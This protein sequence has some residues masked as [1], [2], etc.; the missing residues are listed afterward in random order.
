MWVY[1]ADGRR[2]PGP[3]RAQVWAVEVL[4][5][6]PQA[7]LIYELETLHLMMRRT[8]GRVCASA[9]QLAVLS[10]P[11]AQ[12]QTSERLLWTFQAYQCRYWVAAQEVRLL[13]LLLLELL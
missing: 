13:A 8:M 11:E 9:S 7:M 1:Q 6:R 2:A 5:V 4:G 12:V 3:V 10:P